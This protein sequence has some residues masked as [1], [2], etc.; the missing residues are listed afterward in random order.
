MNRRRTAGAAIAAAGLLP[1]AVLAGPVANADSALRVGKTAVKPPPIGTLWVSSQLGNSLAEFAP[2]AGANAKPV[3][4]ITGPDTGLKT[5][6]AVAVDRD[7]RVWA[8]NF[9]T[10]TI[11]EYAANAKGDAKPVLK[12]SGPDTGLNDPL[13]M[14]MTASGAIWVVDF[15]SNALEQFAPGAHGDAKPARVIVGALTQIDNAAGIAVSPDGAHVWVTVR[16]SPGPPDPPQ[17]LEFSGTTHGNVAPTAIIRGSKTKLDEPDGIAVGVAGNAPV[18][19]NTDGNGDLGLLSF[20]AGAHGNAK[21]V[22]EVSGLTSGLNSQGL[23]TMDAVGDVWVP[24]QDNSIVEYTPRQN[25]DVKPH[26]VISG[27][28]SQLDNPDAVAIYDTAPST[29]TAVHANASKKSL[30][31]TW[32]APHST[33]GGLLGYVVRAKTKHGKWT[34]VATTTARSYVKKHPSAG[35]SYDVEAVNNAGYSI[36]T[37]AITLTV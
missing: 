31:L 35:T 32:K 22:R 18:T 19:I 15:Q 8:A 21:P 25:G 30:R 33:G 14:A 34:I 37:K 13:A 23:I 26:R 3:A 27:A 5:P 11:T 9:G 17:L 28:D 4:V 16:N 10:A 20:A 6:T 1:L 29:P 12:I 24:N 2:N 7:G 36:P